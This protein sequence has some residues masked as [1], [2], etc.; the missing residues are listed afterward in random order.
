M[1]VPPMRDSTEP[2]KRD[3]GRRAGIFRTADL[4]LVASA[5]PPDVPALVVGE[6]CRLNSGSP[7]F[8]VVEVVDDRL[9]VAWKNSADETFEATMDRAVVR[10]IP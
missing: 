5:P 9:V 1:P 3:D 10:R 2:W 7:R 8:T 6:R 4:R